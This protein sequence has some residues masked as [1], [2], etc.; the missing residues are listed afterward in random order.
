[1]NTQVFDYTPPLS[2]S[3]SLRYDY[4]KQTLFVRV[5]ADSDAV[6][7]DF[8]DSAG[9][10]YY[11]D[12]YPRT[13]ID[14]YFDLFDSVRYYKG[15]NY[16]YSGIYGHR[17]ERYTQNI[18]E[19]YV[20]DHFQGAG[21][22]YGDGTSTLVQAIIHADSAHT[23]VYS[24]NYYPT[25]EV[26]PVTRIKNY[27]FQI[28]LIVG[29]ALSG[30]GLNYIDSVKLYSNYKKDSLQFDNPSLTMQNSPSTNTYTISQSLDVGLLKSGYSF[31]YRF[32]AKDKGIVPRFAHTPDSGYFSAILDTATRVSLTINPSS[33]SLL[34]NY[35]NPFNST[36]LIEFTLPVADRAMIA[37]FDLLGRRAAVVFDDYVSA[38]PHSARWKATDLPSGIYFYELRTRNYHDRKKLLLLK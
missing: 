16:P 4:K 20:Y 15:V 6:L 12:H 9:Y 11:Y 31:N 23:I 21:G 30:Y 18:G 2:Y 29:H 5:T 36:T 33:F 17:S 10:T 24:N 32:E 8:E 34:Q 27:N 28:N 19:F 25:L 38:G 7:V 35:P 22:Y 13:I 14:G 37:V 26:A 1:V 3:S